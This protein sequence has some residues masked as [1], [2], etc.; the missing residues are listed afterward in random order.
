M[1]RTQLNVLLACCLEDRHEL[2]VADTLVEALLRFLSVSVKEAGAP[3]YSTVF[4][5][6]PRLLGPQRMEVLMALDATTAFS[7]EVRP[8]LATLISYAFSAAMG[9]ADNFVVGVLNVTDALSL[10]LL[11]M[12]TM[13]ARAAKRRGGGLWCSAP[14]LY[15][16]C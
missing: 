13:S 6:V 5:L 11:A 10:W 8:C 14:I 1:I 2:A 3:I 4:V 9:S 15:A 7:L 12:P 16:Q